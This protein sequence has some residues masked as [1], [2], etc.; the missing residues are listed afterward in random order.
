[1]FDHRA[2]DT[3][4][5]GKAQDWSRESVSPSLG[6]S[7]Q[8]STTKSCATVCSPAR[9]GASHPCTTDRGDR[10]CSPVCTR[11]CRPAH[12][13]TAPYVGAWISRRDGTG[14]TQRAGEPCTMTLG[15]NVSRHGAA[16][17]PVHAAA[18]SGVERKVASVVYSACW[19]L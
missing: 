8:A 4:A 1:M 16:T 12:A 9:L 10:G 19:I 14:G 3:G 6:F 13:P 2:V 18:L 17:R 5:W 11:V 7:A 15:A